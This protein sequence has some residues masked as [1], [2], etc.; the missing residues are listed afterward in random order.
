MGARVGGGEGE[1]RAQVF[2]D[3]ADGGGAFVGEV[4]EHAG[5]FGVSPGPVVEPRDGRDRHFGEQALQYG[6]PP[7]VWVQVVGGVGADGRGDQP[8]VV[9]TQGVLDERERGGA[10]V[11]AVQG[12]QDGAAFGGGALFVEPGDGGQRGAGLD[13]QEGAY[14]VGV[15]KAAVAVA[16]A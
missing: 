13:E 10:E 4:A 2:G 14:G 7:G 16:A 1:D 8:G 11:E 5:E 3:G 9:G 12:E 15:L 6:V